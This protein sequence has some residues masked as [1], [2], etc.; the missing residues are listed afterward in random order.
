MLLG[1]DATTLRGNK[2]GVGYYTSRLLERLTRVGGRANPID[3][4]LILS[5]RPVA[6]GSVPR[7]TPTT[8]GS[9][10]LAERLDAEL[11]APRSQGFPARPLPLHELPRTGARRNSLRRHLSRH[12]AAAHGHVS[13]L[14]Q[15][16]LDR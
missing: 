5:N 1:F 13:P 2:T 7:S 16:S 8:R 12:D 6:I 15:A 3:E 10:S 11:F 4:V 14:A 9:V